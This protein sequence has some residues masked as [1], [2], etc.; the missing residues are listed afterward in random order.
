MPLAG[1]QYIQN[2]IAF[3]FFVNALQFQNSV[4]DYS[5]GTDS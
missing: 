2:R 4:T 3:G 1:T 5:D